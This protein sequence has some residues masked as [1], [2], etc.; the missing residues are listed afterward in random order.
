MTKRV[1]SLTTLVSPA[2]RPAPVR[3]LGKV[4]SLPEKY[5][6]DVLIVGHNGEDVIR[7]G[8]QRKTVADFLASIEDNRLAK[9]VQ[10][11]RRLDV[12]V[13][14]IEGRFRFSA[15]GQLPSSWGRQW[16]QKQIYGVLWSLMMEGIWVAEV[17]NATQFARYVELLRGYVRKP[18]HRFGD[19]R[20]AAPAALWG[21]SKGAKDFGT[22]VLQGMPNI[23]PEL[24]DRIWDH[25]G[26]LPW[27]WTC[28]REEMME[29]E[30]I[31]E[32]TVE[33]L[34]N[35]MGDA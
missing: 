3:A 25:F 4:H 9:E 7:V 14:L 31:G 23:G 28:S 13:L 5:G 11:M 20:N 27:G 16:T 18:R 12:K 24:A 1:G 17:D 2:E 29:I 19:R 34:W 15:D 10:Q 6:A 33:K 32:K 30:G 8:I 21:S 35:V 22:W 26:G